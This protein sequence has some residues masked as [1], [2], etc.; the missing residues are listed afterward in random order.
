MDFGTDRQEVLDKT[1][2]K[3]WV[4]QA[5]DGSYAIDEA[6]VT[7]YVAGLA[8]KYDTVDSERSFTTTS[9]STMRSTTEHRERLKLFT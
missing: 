2:L 6:K 4:V 9:G 3:D 5:E 8:Q 1:T 7:E